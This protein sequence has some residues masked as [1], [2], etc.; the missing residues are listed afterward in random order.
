MVGGSGRSEQGG[1]ELVVTSLSEP[2]S[3]NGD[4]VRL[5]QVVSNLLNN[6][7]KYS[8][9]GGRIWPIGAGRPRIGGDVV[10]RACLRQWRYGKAGAGGLE[11]AQQR[12]KIQRAWWPDLA[13]RSR[14]AA[15]WW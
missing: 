2:V 14:A 3:V 6:A 13:D 12:G 1:H 7:A 15:N 10:V 9:H 4:M 5:A 8:A 11:P